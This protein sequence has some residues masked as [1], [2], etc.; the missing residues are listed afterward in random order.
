[1]AWTSEGRACTE[2]YQAV[3]EQFAVLAFDSHAAE[4]YGTMA[5]VIRRAG[6]PGYRSFHRT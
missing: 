3:R 6:R 2:R 1:M 5:A 4:I